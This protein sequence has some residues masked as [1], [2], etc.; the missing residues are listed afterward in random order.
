MSPIPSPR[1]AEP[2]PPSCSGS[3]L[4]ALFV[5][6]SVS[7][8]VV[9]EGRALYRPEPAWSGALYRKLEEQPM[10]RFAIRMI[11]YFAWNNR[12]ASTM[13]VWMPLV[14]KA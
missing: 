8:T 11:P 7:N 4:A 3:F 1:Y 6:C 9:L 14:L 2:L 13:T 5:A 12:G 10:K